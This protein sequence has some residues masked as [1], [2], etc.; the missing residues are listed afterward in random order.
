MARQIMR[1]L[2][3]KDAIRTVIGCVG[4]DEHDDIWVLPDVVME[5]MET[6]RTVDEMLVQFKTHKPL[7][8]WM[9]SELISKSFGPFLRRRMQEERIYT[10]IDGVPVSKDKPTRARSIQGRMRMRKVRFPR[11]A[12]WWPEA[13]SQI[14]RFPYGAH[15]DF[16]DWLAH[17]G[18]GLIKEVGASAPKK[19]KPDD[20]PG[21]A[22]FSGF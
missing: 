18:Q 5:R 16:V 9:E 12:P 22:L 1:S 2:R 11:F 20:R 19:T 7:L 8:W 13:R 6:D 4:I 15:D 3:S 10:S 21:P 14:L 17:I